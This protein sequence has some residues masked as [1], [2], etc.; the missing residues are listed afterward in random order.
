ML[1]WTYST[2]DFRTENY[3]LVFIR[4]TKDRFGLISGEL[5]YPCNSSEIGGDNKIM[6]VAPSTHNGNHNKLM[7]SST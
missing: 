4:K 1:C 2:Q 7:T 5:R 6:Q 3:V